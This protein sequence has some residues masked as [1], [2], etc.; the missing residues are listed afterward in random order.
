MRKKLIVLFILA[1]CLF[2]FQGAVA[3]NTLPNDTQGLLDLQTSVLE[4]LCNTDKKVYP[5]G[6]GEYHCPEDIVPGS[7]II[8]ILAIMS[9]TGIAQ[10]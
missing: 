5:F 4:K 2:F 8:Y 7:Y 10:V 1:V 6:L 9:Q 3:E